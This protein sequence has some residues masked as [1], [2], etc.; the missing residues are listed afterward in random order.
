MV[1]CAGAVGVGG[2]RLLGGS[3]GCCTGEWRG[4]GTWVFVHGLDSLWVIRI[5]M[6]F[7]LFD[8]DELLRSF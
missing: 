8:P 5:V 4:S 6:M 3:R 1:I 2:W 7:G